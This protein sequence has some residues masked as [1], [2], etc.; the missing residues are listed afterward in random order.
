M[1]RKSFGSILKTTAR[2]L[3]W[4]AGIW[5][6]L[7][8]VLEIALSSPVLTRIVN[9]YA[10]EYVDGNLNFGKASLSFFKRFPAAVLT[11]ED[12]SVT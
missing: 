9:S 10:S 3:A 2:A 8:V 12:V 11:L 5:V 1:S 7:L 4:I 6:A